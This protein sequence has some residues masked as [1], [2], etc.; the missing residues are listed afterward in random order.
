MNQSNKKM[1][2][3][4]LLSPHRLD[5]PTAVTELGQVRTPFDQD[6][7]RIIFSH[8]FRSLQDKTQVFP[9]PENDFVHNR[10]THSLEVSSVGRSLG[11]AVGEQVLKK[12]ETLAEKGLS[13]HD[14]G[15][16]VAAACLA[17]D[18][19]N[20][21]FG[22]AGESTISN[23]FKND[24]K[25][26]FFK[27][28][29]SKSE[30]QD[31]ISFEGNAQGFRLL[32]DPDNKGLQCTAA[33][34]ATFTKYPRSSGSKKTPGRKSQK[35][36]G[37]YQS[38][39]PAFQK[40]AELTG[41]LPLGE[42]SWCRHPLAFLVEAADDICYL[43]IDLEDATR[44]GLI[45]FEKTTELL[46][47]IIGSRFDANKLGAIEDSLQKLA[48]L[49]AMAIHQL[50]E[51]CSS[52][53]IQKEEEL[54]TGTFDKALTEQLPYSAALKTISSISIKEIYQSRQVIEREALGLSVLTSLV[55]CFTEAAFYCIF[56]REERMPQH[57]THFSLL[58]ESI[59][60]KL[61]RDNISIYQSLRWVLDFISGLTDRSALKMH[62]LL[63]GQVSVL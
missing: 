26:L 5:K 7:D 45:P 6:Y 1:E 54:L 47:P 14:F 51:D 20:P 29:V 10:L 37:Y 33:T 28:K 31:L 24:P 52:V 21:P 56:N 41:L 48:T 23:F 11:R 53:F 58:P 50:I 4:T 62:K 16:V 40:T 12:N 38:N 42:Q 19:G 60:M 63:T 34:L 3:G 57:G 49:R 32:N 44:L 13:P 46:A 59:R 55:T 18:I 2:W 17:H 9:L 43:I 27:E 35:K 36:Y 61:Q 15:A 39:Y 22:H 25:G 8:P 30:W